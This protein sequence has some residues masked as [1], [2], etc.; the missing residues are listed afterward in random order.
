M[1]GDRLEE[2][3]LRENPITAYDPDWDVDS[4]EDALLVFIKEGYEPYE[5]GISLFSVF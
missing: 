3:L 2:L 1:G 4:Y 5:E